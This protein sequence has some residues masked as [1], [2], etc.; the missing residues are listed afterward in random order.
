[1]N[2]NLFQ[3]TQPLVARFAALGIVLLLAVAGVTPRSARAATFI[4]TN[5]ND[6]GSGS[7]RQA[8]TDANTTTGTHTITFSIG[9]MIP[10]GSPLPA[11]PSGKTITID[12]VGQSV[13]ISGNSTV[14]VI[15][16]NAG[17]T[18]YLRNLTVTQG[19]SSSGGGANNIGTLNV[20]NCTFSTNSS[21]TGGGGI[22]N[23]GTLTVTSSTFSGNTASVEGGA[24]QNNSGGTATVVNSTFSGNSALYGGGISNSGTLN[25]TNNTFSGNTVS[26][27]GSGAGIYRWSGAA[28]LRNTIVA[29]ST[30]GGNCSGTIING[31]NNIEDRATCG[32][33]SSNG[34]LSN[35]DPRV[36]A[37]TNNGGRTQ[38]LALQAGSPAINAG[39]ATICA[40]AVG[41]PSYGAGGA[42]QRGLPRRIAFCDVGAFEAQ[43]INITT[44]AGSNQRALIHAAFPNPLQAIVQDVNNN[45]LGGVLIV[46]TGPASGAG[47][48]SGGT[49]ATNASGIA[50]FTAT[51][52]GTPGGPYTVIA[53]GEGSNHPTKTA[54]VL[55]ADYSLTNLAPLFLPLILR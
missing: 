28:T 12:G 47:I 21:T 14:R 25:V 29:N 53:S 50:S 8:I 18:L 49:V 38:T 16:V 51:A 10:L 11:I 44:F 30:L 19:S 6:S 36:G 15:E 41:S 13:T 24:I 54:S 48:A 20:A 5:P 40:A 27:G 4:V 9:G 39:N 34:S 46:F 43:P 33:G 42:D 1:M 2:S 31:G 22:S 55:A 45:T 26:G 35:T 37:L 23:S 32:W 7:L 3:K 52:N 17:A